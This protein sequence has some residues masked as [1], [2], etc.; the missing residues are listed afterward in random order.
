MELS[1][2]VWYDPVSRR[3][4]HRK[5]RL[6]EMGLGKRGLGARAEVVSES[7]PTLRSDRSSP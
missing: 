7:R 6:V 5:K 4:H 1:T 3:S 2:G